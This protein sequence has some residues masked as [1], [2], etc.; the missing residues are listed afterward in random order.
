METGSLYLGPLHSSFLNLLFWTI[1]MSPVTW[2]WFGSVNAVVQLQDK[3][4]ILSKMFLV[5]YVFIDSLWLNILDHIVSV[6]VHTVEICS[7][8]LKCVGKFFFTFLSF[9]IRLKS[10]MSKS[11]F[12]KCNFI[13]FLGF[14]LVL[15]AGGL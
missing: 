1:C 10:I 4:F 11:L 7:V 12:R 14:V 8:L 13:K 6:N 9:V 5:S 3:L 15:D 2:L